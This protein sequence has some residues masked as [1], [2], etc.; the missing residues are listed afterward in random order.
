MISDDVPSSSPA[1]RGRHTLEIML[2]ALKS[3]VEGSAK[4][5]LPLPR[6]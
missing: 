4:I 6:G 2:A 1:Q 3:Q 5:Q